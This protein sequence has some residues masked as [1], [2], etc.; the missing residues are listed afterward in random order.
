MQWKYDATISEARRTVSV[1]H[2]VSVL[3]PFKKKAKTNKI[4]V[5]YEENNIFQWKED[6]SIVNK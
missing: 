5:V 6:L 3:M 1:R 4:F 2:Q